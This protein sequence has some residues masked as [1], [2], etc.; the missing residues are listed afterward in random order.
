MMKW[1]KLSEVVVIILVYGWLISSCN[2]ENQSSKGPGLKTLT[3]IE[4]ISISPNIPGTSIGDFS[5]LSVDSEGSIY[6][7]DV[8]LKKIHHFS[9]K[10]GYLGSLGHKVKGPGEFISLDTKIRVESDTL[11]VKDN[12]AKRISLF[13]RKTYQLI[14]IIN[15]PNTKINSDPIGSLKQ[16]FP[17]QNGNILVAFVNSYTMAPKTTDP[18]RMTTIS[19]LSPYG[20]FIEKNCFQFSTPFPAGQK[21]AILNS[22]AINVFTGLSF[23]PDIKM[24]IGPKEHLYVGKSDSL[25]IREYDR[26]WKII[27]NLSY[28]YVPP[29]LTNVNIDSIL[30]NRSNSFEKAIEEVGGFPDK[31]PVLQNFLIDDMGRSWIELVNRSEEHTSEL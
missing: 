10:G 8:R 30:E 15:I 19:I 17:L 23:Y 14:R 27:D 11:Y 22:G 3:L 1:I 18:P 24:A 20:N 29:T 6:A 9:S 16:M 31:W 21:F 12:I 13:D 5:G 7:A 28:N 26:S 2:S 4:D 25:L